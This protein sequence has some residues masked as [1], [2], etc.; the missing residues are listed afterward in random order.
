MDILSHGLWGS[1]TFGRK[2]KKSFWTAFLFG[3]APDFFSFGAFFISVYLG[4]QDF[5]PFSSEPPDPA[6]IPSYVGNLYNVSHSLVIFS[7]VFL[8]V[9]FIFKKPFWEMSA[10]G[11][12]IL[13]D[14]PTHSYKFFPTPFLWPLSSFKFNGWHWVSPWI[15]WPNVAIL[16]LL[17]LWF[18]VIKP[19]N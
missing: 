5:P 8:L 10:W 13:F 11:L 7:M 4:I 3:I 6:L 14:I 9:R 16:L 15:F 2:N 19:K 17:Y 12:H 18:F 1:I